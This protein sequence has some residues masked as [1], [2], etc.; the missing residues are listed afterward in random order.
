MKFKAILA[1]L[2]AGSFVAAQPLAAAAQADRLASP[3]EEAEG[4][5]GGVLWV[6][7]AF[8]GLL[9]IAELTDVIDVLG[10]DDEPVSP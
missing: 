7:L 2:A 5:F 4:A 3:T 6:A 8:I 10:D 1:A 9:A